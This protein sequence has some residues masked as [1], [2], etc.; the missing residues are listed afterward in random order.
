MELKLDGRSL[1]FWLVRARLARRGILLGTREVWNTEWGKEG[2]Q[3]C[4]VLAI[5]ELPRTK[6]AQP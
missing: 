5:Y 4:R 3:V 1:S 2:S 6:T